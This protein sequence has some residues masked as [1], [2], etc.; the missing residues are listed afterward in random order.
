MHKIQ[1]EEGLEDDVDKST[2]SLICWYCHLIDAQN[3]HFNKLKMS[4]TQV[5]NL[6]V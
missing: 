2:W 1:T 5:K 3:G 6:I 4:P